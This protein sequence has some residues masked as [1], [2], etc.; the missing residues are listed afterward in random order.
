MSVYKNKSGKWCAKFRY[1][2]WNGEVKQKKKEGFLTKKEA[3]TF[4]Q[5]F[6]NSFEQTPTIT[7]EHLASEYL[8]DCAARLKPT[9][10]Q[11]KAAIIE[12]RILP[13]FGKVPICDIT[14]L[15][16][17]KWQT[18]LID[19]GSFSETYLRTVHNQL[20]A[21]FNYACRYYKLASNPARECGSMGKKK[22]ESM[23][24]WTPEEFNEFLKAVSDK[25]LSNVIFSLLFYSGMRE[26]ELLALTLN[27]FDFEENKISINKTYA[28]LGDRDIIQPPKTPKSK[29]V[30]TM[31]PQIMNLVNEFA[32][33]LYDLSPNERL[34][35]TTKSYLYHEINRGTKK[36]DIKRIRVHDLRHS[37][38]SL[39]I[40]MGFSPLLIS[41]RLG[42]ENI[43]TTLS[44]Y[45]HLYPN[46]QSEVAKSL[47]KLIDDF[48]CTLSVPKFLRI[49]FF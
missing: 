31:P 1:R 8:K 15:T 49:A 28:R 42:H 14:V 18:E 9:T 24:F 26:G 47:S 48:K 36:A 19:N 33:S 29:R 12:K 4:E 7:F 17:R 11:T 40:E 30:I 20:T 2:T 16:V 22:A 45:S 6:L 39:L 10:I 35:R 27:D 32:K 37:H 21:M 5:D 25:A 38:A 13:Y 41:E 44:T 3:L 34:F 43:E 23:Q 46:K